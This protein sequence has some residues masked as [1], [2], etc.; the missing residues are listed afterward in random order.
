M[1]NFADFRGSRSLFTADGAEKSQKKGTASFGWQFFFRKSPIS[2]CTTRLVPY[3]WCLQNFYINVVTRRQIFEVKW[4]EIKFC[5]TSMQGTPN[6]PFQRTVML[7]VKYAT[8]EQMYVNWPDIFCCLSVR[9]IVSCANQWRV[10]KWV[11]FCRTITNIFNN[12]IV[13]NISCIL[14]KVIFKDLQGVWVWLLRFFVTRSPLR[15]LSS[16]GSATHSRL[17][18]DLCSFS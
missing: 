15:W 9:K 8:M 6:G 16:A 3:I 2:P 11:Y 5:T 4:A 12:A 7:G 10:C 18:R 14:M 17:T 1:T 13:I